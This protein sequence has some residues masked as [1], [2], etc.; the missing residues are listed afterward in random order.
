MKTLYLIVLAAGLVGFGGSVGST[1]AQPAVVSAETTTAWFGQGSARPDPALSLSSAVR[2]WHK[3]AVV[4]HL[5]VAAFHDSD[6][7]GVGDL[8]G[9]TER[10]GTLRDLGVNTLWLSPFFLNASGARNLHGYD[11]IDHHQVDPRF[12]T[13]EDAFELVREAHARGLRLIFDFVPN[14]L[15]TRHPWFIESRDPESPKR[16]SFKSI[17][18]SAAEIVNLV[19]GRFEE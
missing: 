16:D 18:E 12:G 8:A 17:E 3:D 19:G 5:W 13:T 1:S 14:H 15:S 4:Y 7:D 2:D 6:G 11:V 10:L 9:I